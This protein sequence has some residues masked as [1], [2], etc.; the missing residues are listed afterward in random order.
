MKWQ[1]KCVEAR[2]EAAL[3]YRVASTRQDANSHFKKR[4]KM[5]RDY[6]MDSE[7]RPRNTQMF[8]LLFLACLA[9]SPE[10]HICACHC[11]S[12]DLCPDEIA[13]RVTTLG[14]FIIR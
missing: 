10:L 7:S 8:V 5:R 3:G 1:H 13:P 2:Y 11:N 6:F 9:L 4:F 14:Y 12:P